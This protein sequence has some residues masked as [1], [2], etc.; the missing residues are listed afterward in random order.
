[1]KIYKPSKLDESII[2][3]VRVNRE[4]DLNNCIET[5]TDRFEN[6]ILF[7]ERGIGKSFLIRLIELKLASEFPN[8]LSIY[9][10]M[11]GLFS[12]EEDKTKFDRININDFPRLILLEM[13]RTIW[14]DKFNKEYSELRSGLI[15]DTSIFSKT[16]HKK[17]KSIY[18]FLMTSNREFHKSQVNEVGFSLA[19][20][21]GKKEEISHSWKEN[22]IDSFEFFEYIKE[23]K[24]EILLKL[25]VNRILVICD[26]SNHLSMSSQIELISK[27]GNLFSN[28]DIQMIFLSD[29]DKFENGNTKILADG[30]ENIYHL[31]GFKEVKHLKELASKYLAEEFEIS[32]EALEILF[33]IFKGNPRNSLNTLY[34]SSKALGAQPSKII[35]AKTMSLA[36]FTLLKKMNPEMKY[37]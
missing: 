22:P 13:C 29:K 31:E 19:V 6:L 28:H 27:Y 32:D 34:F 35:D 16:S 23:F 14:V 37:S 15:E 17:I 5:I 10:N 4:N 25:G 26:E 9:L 30:F 3:E 18:N 20:K 24:K 33:H 11:T 12:K 21:G 1:M 2:R 7:G 36:C 8:F